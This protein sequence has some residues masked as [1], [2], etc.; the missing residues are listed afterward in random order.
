MSH[1]K[2]IIVLGMTL[3]V[4]AGS[5]PTLAATPQPPT[6]TEETAFQ[7][8]FDRVDNAAATSHSLSEF[9]LKLDTICQDKILARY[10]ALENLANRIRTFHNRNP[11][12]YILGIPIGETTTNNIGRNLLNRPSSHFVLSFGAYHRL[13]PLKQNTLTLI[14]ER[15]STWHYGSQS[16]LLRGRTLIIDRHPFGIGQRVIGPQF[17][18]MRGFHGIYWDHE[19]RLTGTTYH[20]FMGQATRIHAFDLTPFQ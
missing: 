2:T 5:L 11:R 8:F 4:L 16:N 14:K 20:F 3:L 15:L 17:G 13:C 12:F 19:S 9:L 1:R 18:I 6:Q 10:P 7:A